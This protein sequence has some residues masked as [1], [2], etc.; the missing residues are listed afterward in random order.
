MR[1]D[2]G[3]TAPRSGTNGRGA[4]HQMREAVIALGRG[5]GLHLPQR[6]LIGLD[7]RGGAGR[8]TPVVDHH[9]CV[10]WQLQPP[11]VVLERAVNRLGWL[12][13]KWP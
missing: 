5:G 9:L 7:E 3:K 10:E 11:R 8:V 6:R 1:V 12:W 2:A 4:H 13:Q